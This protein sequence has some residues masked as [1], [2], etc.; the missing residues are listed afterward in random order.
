MRLEAELPLIVKPTVTAL[1]LSGPPGM[2]W[3]TNSRTALAAWWVRMGA[4]VRGAA[5]CTSWQRWQARAHVA[6]PPSAAESA[7]PAGLPPL[8]LDLLGE[9]LGESRSVT[10]V[11]D[12]SRAWRRAGCGVGPLAEACRSRLPL[13]PAACR[14][15]EL[16]WPLPPGGPP[17]SGRPPLCWQDDQSIYSFLCAEPGIFG[18]FTRRFGGRVMCLQTNFRC[19]L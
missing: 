14:W 7:L 16:W 9:L 17:H 5:A 6:C 10:V 4:S 2:C 8:Q 15:Y 1:L 12:V 13:T 18:E 3:W 11:G 19:C